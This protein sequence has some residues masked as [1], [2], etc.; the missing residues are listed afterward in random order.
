MDGA[1]RIY[2][3]VTCHST[4]AELFSEEM[5]SI[6]G[7]LV[8]NGQPIVESSLP[9]GLYYVFAAFYVFTKDYDTKSVPVLWMIERFFMDCCVTEEEPLA[10]QKLTANLN[11]LADPLNSWS[12]KGT[13]I[14]HI[15]DYMWLNTQIYF[16]TQINLTN[17]G[18][19]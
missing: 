9:V 10:C 15:C 5:T 19:Q 1:N 2:F 3:Q 4:I 6:T 12:S 11:C 16:N 13:T 14:G 7:H 17:I 8:V 18:R